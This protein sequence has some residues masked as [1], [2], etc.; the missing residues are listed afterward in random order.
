MSRLVDGTATSGPNNNTHTRTN[1]RTGRHIDTR[2]SGSAA[3][4]C[5]SPRLASAVSRRRRRR[6]RTSLS[7]SAVGGSRGGE[8]VL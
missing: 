6:R 8:P 5:V 2:Q 1:G 3:A 7:V 4:S